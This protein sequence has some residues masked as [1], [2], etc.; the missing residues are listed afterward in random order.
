MSRVPL[1][2]LKTKLNIQSACHIIRYAQSARHSV[3][4]VNILSCQMASWS[5]TK[6][7]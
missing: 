6:E 1:K 4:H 5:K 3:Y 7:S 2:K